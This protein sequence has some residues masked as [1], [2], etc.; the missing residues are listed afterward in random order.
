MRT[1]FFVSNF[2]PQMSNCNSSL[3]RKNPEDFAKSN[4]GKQL[5]VK[6]CLLSPRVAEPLS[7][8]C[9]DKLSL[10]VE[11]LKHS[12]GSE[13]INIKIRYRDKGVIMNWSLHLLQCEFAAGHQRGGS[14]QGSSALASSNFVT[15]WIFPLKCPN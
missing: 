14:S 12:K 3:L 10:L 15:M 5:E 4:K 9:D 11:S 13:D 2:Y 1:T 6:Y 8:L 7:P